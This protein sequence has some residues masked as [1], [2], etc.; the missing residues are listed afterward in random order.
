M[1][2]KAERHFPNLDPNSNRWRKSGGGKRPSRRLS[3]VF[4]SGNRDTLLRTVGLHEGRG[5]VEPRLYVGK[6]TTIHYVFTSRVWHEEMDEWLRTYP[7]HNSGRKLDLVIVN[8]CLWDVNRWVVLL[9]QAFFQHF[10]GKI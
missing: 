8:S 9:E 1:G 4:H 10:F 5:Y 2:E 3:R 7:D 6:G